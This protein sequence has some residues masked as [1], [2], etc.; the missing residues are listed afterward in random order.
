MAKR[1][2]RKLKVLR[3]APRPPARPEAPEITGIQLLEDLVI[4]LRK[5]DLPLQP[6]GL[7]VFWMEP[8]PG[9]TFQP[10]VWRQ[11]CPLTQQIAYAMLLQDLGIKEWR[12]EGE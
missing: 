7:L 5:L 9:G 4:E 12:G 2:P 3:M 8:K 6:D 11:N 10:H 1:P